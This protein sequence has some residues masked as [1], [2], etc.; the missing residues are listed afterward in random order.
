MSFYVVFIMSK[1]KNSSRRKYSFVKPSDSHKYKHWIKNMNS[2]L[3]ESKIWGNVERKLI[4]LSYFNSEN[5]NTK[6]QISESWLK[7]GQFVN[8]KIIFA[9]N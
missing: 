3:E 5:D 6:H 4:L 1:L 7:K 2:V 9:K 8:I